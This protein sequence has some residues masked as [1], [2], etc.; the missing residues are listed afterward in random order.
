[1]K[2]EPPEDPAKT[3]MEGGEAGG[4]GEQK[5]EAADPTGQ[6]ATGAAAASAGVSTLAV[7]AVLTRD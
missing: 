5:N 3:L 4:P 7:E 6:V 2:N 1:M